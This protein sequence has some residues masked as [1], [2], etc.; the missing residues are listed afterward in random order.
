VSERLPRITGAELLRALRRDGWYLDDQAGSHAHLRH[1]HKRAKLTVAVHRGAIIKPK[2][3]QA[4]LVLVELSVE[5]L[6]RLL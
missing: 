4:T 6:R 2:V 3:L 5:D 1:P